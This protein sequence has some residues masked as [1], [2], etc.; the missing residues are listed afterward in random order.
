[1]ARF[2]S[3][4]EEEQDKKDRY[5]RYVSSAMKQGLSGAAAGKAAKRDA[6]ANLIQRR[7]Q[8]KEMQQGSP[9]GKLTPPVAAPTEDEMEEMIT[10][11]SKK[12]RQ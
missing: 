10:P 4:V 1:M 11:G 5:G 9:G 7:Q 6:L 12:R 8:L 2:K 3:L